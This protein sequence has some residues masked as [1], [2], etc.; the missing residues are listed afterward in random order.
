[1]SSL[2]ELFVQMGQDY[3][4]FCKDLPKIEHDRRLED[5]QYQFTIFKTKDVKPKNQEDGLKK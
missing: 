3:L 1:M 2:K 4:E 5:E